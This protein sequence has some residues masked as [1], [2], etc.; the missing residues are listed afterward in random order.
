VNR[1]VQKEIIVEGVRLQYLD[2]EP[3]APS[4][5]SPLLLLH[6]LLATAE[7]FAD[8]IRNLPTDRRIVALDLL[9]A[10]PLTK[11]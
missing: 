7:T 8:L 11:R 2:L 10:T 1:T 5:K 3:S 4:T 6:Q 9:S